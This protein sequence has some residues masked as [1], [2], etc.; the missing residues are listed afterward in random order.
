MELSYSGLS[1]LTCLVVMIVAWFFVR[2]RIK[3]SGI[4]PSHPVELMHKFFLAFGAFCFFVTIPFYFVYAAQS[5]FGLAM[6]VGFAIGHA[7]LFVALTYTVRMTFTMI[8]QLSSKERYVMIAGGLGVV[9]ILAAT[10][11]TMVFGTHPTYDYAK[12][13]A[14]YHEAPPVAGSIAIG[15]IIAWVPLGILFLV[16]AVKSHSG[17]RIRSLLLGF[18]FILLT[19]VGPL[20]GLAQT[21]AQFLVADLATILSIVMIGAGVVY[22]INTSLTAPAKTAPTQISN[23]A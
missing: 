11:V 5:N 19:A 1:N 13:I 14:N 8:P 6:A 4:S 20:H 3:K 18:G 22:R 2:H 17:Q 9:W 15:A 21:Y 12:H 10:L 16:N 7:L 23:P